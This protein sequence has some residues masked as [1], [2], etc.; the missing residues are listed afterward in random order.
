MSQLIKTETKSPTLPKMQG[1]LFAA[2]ED[3]DLSS[4][5]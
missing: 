4:T 5:P 3:R 2:F 1:K